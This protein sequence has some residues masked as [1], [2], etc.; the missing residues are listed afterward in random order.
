MRLSPVSATN[1]QAHL[2]TRNHSGDYSSPSATPRSHSRA[3]SHSWSSPYAQHN[4]QVEK[5]ANPTTHSSNHHRQISIPNANNDLPHH[6]RSPQAKPAQTPRS[7]PERPYES[8]TSSFP[9]QPQTGNSDSPPPIERYLFE[10]PAQPSATQRPL[11]MKAPSSASRINRSQSK[12]S[13]PH[14]HCS[15]TFTVDCSFNSGLLST[16]GLVPL[17]KGVDASMNTK[18]RVDFKVGGIAGI[19]L[20]EALHENFALDNADEAVLP[21]ESDRQIHLWITVSKDD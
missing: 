6:P 17:P 1:P 10:F 13:R 8:F 7:N 5:R 12:S 21:S 19:K 18:R 16:P 20:S 11:A 4:P 15:A 14:R 3:P 9:L 2:H